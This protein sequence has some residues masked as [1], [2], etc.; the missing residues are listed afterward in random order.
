MSSTDDLILKST[1]FLYV[2][3]LSLQLAH[4]LVYGFDVKVEVEVKSGRVELEL[5]SFCELIAT[6]YSDETWRGSIH[7]IMEAFI[8]RKKYIHLHGATT[9]CGN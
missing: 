5:R 1:F 6:G 4:D 7:M 8:S 3:S 9:H 2:L